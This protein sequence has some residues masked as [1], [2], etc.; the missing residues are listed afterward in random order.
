[1]R[2]VRVKSILAATMGIAAKGRA[3]TARFMDGSE[4]GSRAAKARLPIAASGLAGMLFTAFAPV[5]A[6]AVDLYSNT[7]IESLV[8]YNPGDPN[9]IVFDDIPIP[10]SLLKVAGRNAD[11]VALD[12]VT[13]G[14]RRLA[15]SPSVAVALF[16]AGWESGFLD[17][18][19]SIDQA[20]I[21]YL[22]AQ[23]LPPSIATPITAPIAFSLAANP[24][25]IPLVYFGDYGYLALG[26]AFS[27]PAASNGWR[28]MASTTNDPSIGCN[29]GAGLGPSNLGCFWEVDALSGA[30][31]VYNGFSTSI[32][33]VAGSFYAQVHGRPTLAP[34]PSPLP[35]MGAL[36]AFSASRRLRRRGQRRDPRPCAR[37]MHAE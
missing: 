31:F 23:G 26:V 5:P 37:W 28:V 27:N 32:G 14:I 24:V 8:R 18:S 17:T 10:V 19:F 15:S 35:L 29:A 12:G 21:Q 11:S 33:P 16:A 22:G 2:I 3:A 13:V 4:L 20:S 30:E 34:S 9:I 1:M 25:Q 36:A 7:T 6:G